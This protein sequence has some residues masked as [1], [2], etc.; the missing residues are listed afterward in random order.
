MLNKEKRKRDHGY[1]TS[2]SSS[3]SNPSVPKKSGDWKRLKADKK[4]A[5]QKNSWLYKDD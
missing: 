1:T 5:K 3:S 4:V 2:G